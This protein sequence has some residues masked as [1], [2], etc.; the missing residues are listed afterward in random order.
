MIVSANPAVVSS[1][2]ACE[3]FS[4]PMADVFEEWLRTSRRQKQPGERQ[5]HTEQRSSHTAQRTP[6]LMRFGLHKMDWMSNFVL[7]RDGNWEIL[8]WVDLAP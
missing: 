8:F 2:L 1:P 4:G 7:L 5:C 3:R 6:G